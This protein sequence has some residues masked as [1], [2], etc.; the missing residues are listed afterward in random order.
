[1]SICRL[2]LQLAVVIQTSVNVKLRDL[3]TRQ[4]ISQVVQD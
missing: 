3:V 1:M 4:L 2:N